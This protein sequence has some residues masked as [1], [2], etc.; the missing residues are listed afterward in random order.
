MIIMIPRIIHQ[1]WISEEIPPEGQHA[2]RSWR[3]HHPDWQ[4][5]L[6]TDQDNRHLVAAHYPTL[7]DWYDSLP[8]AIL[9][10]DVA[11][12]NKLARRWRQSKRMLQATLSWWR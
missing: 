2:H 7:L 11:P 9:K 3:L 12:D 10:A 5:R 4:Y 1:T 8:Y 6:W